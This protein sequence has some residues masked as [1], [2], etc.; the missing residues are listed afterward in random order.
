MRF[1]L[2]NLPL[3]DISERIWGEAVR[4]PQ[5][6]IEEVMSAIYSAADR[7]NERDGNEV[8]EFRLKCELCG[9]PWPDRPIPK[10]VWVAG[11]L[12][13]LVDVRTVGGEYI[14]ITDFRERASAQGAN[15][16]E[17][18]GMFVFYNLDPVETPHAFCREDFALVFPNWFP[19]R[20]KKRTGGA[21]L[22]Q[23]LP[24][25]MCKIEAKND[26]YTL[27][28]EVYALREVVV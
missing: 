8:A 19:K 9:K 18:T 12:F 11:R 1:F 26:Q 5:Y 25:G 13:E 23:F 22:L 27:S 4:N 21:T 3:S 10:T 7:N 17:E 6:L 28:G 20:K 16:D 14:T 15:M 2:L 24:T